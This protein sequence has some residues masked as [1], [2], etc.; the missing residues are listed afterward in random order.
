M[1]ISVCDVET[2][3]DS[4]DHRLALL[5]GGSVKEAVFRGFED[6]P[7][8]I[9]CFREGQVAL[10][11]RISS[12]PRPVGIASRGWDCRSPSEWATGSLRRSSS[13]GPLTK[14]TEDS[15]ANGKASTKA[16]C[17][18]RSVKTGS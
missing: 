16:W 14:R 17:C 2:T 6:L 3:P 10:P 7:R 11:L 9:A 4:S 13:N 12:T 18:E 5:C 15:D 8:M 1:G